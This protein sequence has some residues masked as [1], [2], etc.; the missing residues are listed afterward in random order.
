MATQ[1]PDVIKQRPMEVY[2]KAPETLKGSQS[3]YIHSPAFTD[4]YSKA[5]SEKY[6]SAFDWCF[7]SIDSV[8]KI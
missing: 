3:T 2:L 1:W 4:K 6:I 7:S 5:A 8:F